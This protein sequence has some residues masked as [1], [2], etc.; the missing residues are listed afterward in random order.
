MRAI[1]MATALPWLVEKERERERERQK[2]NERPC[3]LSGGV[4]TRS[5]RKVW[6]GV[7]A[8]VKPMVV[9]LPRLLTSLRCRKSLH[10]PANESPS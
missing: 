7:V 1:C 9:A 3:Q 4:I 5:V 2:K 6:T 8:S 10:V